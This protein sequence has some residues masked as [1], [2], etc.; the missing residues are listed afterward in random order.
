MY[1]ACGPP[2]CSP[3]MLLNERGRV[4]IGDRDRGRPLKA[5]VT[6][7]KIEAGVP[8]LVDAKAFHGLYVTRAGIF[9]ECG[10]ER[11]LGERLCQLRHGVPTMLRQGR[12]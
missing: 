9:G 1:I 3:Q 4:R 7:Q 10:I 12:L 2:R 5:L 11:P 8:T 6:V